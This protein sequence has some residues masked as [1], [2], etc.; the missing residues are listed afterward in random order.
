[1]SEIYS[2]IGTSFCQ[3]VDADRCRQPLTPGVTRQVVQRFFPPS[4][5]AFLGFDHHPFAGK[6]NNSKIPD[7]INEHYCA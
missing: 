5:L 1:M 2:D 6:Q 4:G 3:Q 7:K